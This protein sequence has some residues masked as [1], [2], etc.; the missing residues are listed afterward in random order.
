MRAVLAAAIAWLACLGPSSAERFIALSDLH[1]DPTADPALVGELVTAQVADWAAILERGRDGFGR[2]GRDA[3]W[4]L[5][6]SA[7]DQ[8]RAVEPDPAFLL[9][10][11]DL[12]AHGFRAKFLAA[13]PQAGETAYDNFVIKT[14]EFLADQIMARFPGRRVFLALGNNDDFCGDYRLAP[15]GVFL[16]DSER[17]AAALLGVEDARAFAS[18]WD[19]GIGYVLPNGSI[20]GL[21]MV[22]LNSVF[23]SPGYDDAC[24]PDAPRDPGLAAMDW[25]AGRLAEARG[26]GEKV[27][28]FLHIP[29]GGDAWATLKHGACRGT[30][31]AMWTAPETERFLGL[32]R[33]H[34]DTVGAIFAGHTHMDEFRLLGDPA[35]PDGAVLVTPGISPVFGQNPGFH[36]YEVD[37]SGRLTDRETWALTNLAAIG[38]GVAPVWRL[39]YRFD[40]LWGLS[41]LDRSTLAVLAGRIATDPATQAYWYSTF[42]TGRTAAWGQAAGVADLP[43]IEFAAYRC[44]ITA[45]APAAYRAC[46]CER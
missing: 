26:R 35:D 27:W 10:T 14:V 40:G 7:L 19:S 46:V 1:L 29:P 4:P 8:M 45:V 20:P 28:L 16:A 3:T 31:Q 36:I 17:A 44:A 43:P 39:E 15:D 18:A 41:G 2:F 23:F 42:R 6:R 9:L 33:E 21:R 25:L 22:F 32:I 5:V 24:A 38:P 34:A 12:L 30:T 37:A 13:A 11:G